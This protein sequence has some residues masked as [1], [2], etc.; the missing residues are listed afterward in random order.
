MPFTNS[1]SS[2]FFSFRHPYKICLITLQPR[3]REQRFGADPPLILFIVC[4]RDKT[5]A[6]EGSV[7]SAMERK[8]VES[9][10]MLRKSPAQRSDVSLAFVFH[11][12]IF[13]FR[14]F[15][16]VRS[17]PLFLS[18]SLF[19]VLFFEIFFFFAHAIVFSYIFVLLPVYS[20]LLLF[21]CSFPSTM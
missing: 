14:S 19:L 16:S 17:Y 6:R 10:V 15:S 8:I 5:S 9:C 18:L 7:E 13:S 20:F 3:L 21:C 11:L 12:I 1:F 4:P 2:I